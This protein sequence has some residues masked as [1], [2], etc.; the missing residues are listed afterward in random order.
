MKL[1][2]LRKLI[3]R[4]ELLQ[5]KFDY[6]DIDKQI[7]FLSKILVIL[8]FKKKTTYKNKKIILQSPFEYSNQMSFTHLI[9]RKNEKIFIF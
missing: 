5:S 6:S 1:K 9:N 7:L 3:N 8:I 2:I 4:I